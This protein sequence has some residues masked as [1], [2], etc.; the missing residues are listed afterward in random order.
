MLT[1]K[2]FIKKITRLSTDEI[3]D[4]QIQFISVYFWKYK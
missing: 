1:K 2:L 4:S 3:K